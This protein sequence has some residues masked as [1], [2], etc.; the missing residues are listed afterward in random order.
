[1]KTRTK[2]PDR[3]LDVSRQLFNEKGFAATTTTE[4]AAAVG[5]A[6][7]NLTYHFSTKLDL[8]RALEEKAR[9]K[10]RSRRAALQSGPIADDYVEHLLFAM[11]LTWENR[12]MLRDGA[13]YSTGQSAEPRKTE[14]EAD[15]DEL[16]TLVQRIET[17]GMFRKDLGIVLEELTRS[18]WIVSRYWMDYLRETEG[19]QNI[20]WKDQ[21]RGI[22]QHYA[23]L[24][25]CLTATARKAFS[26]ALQHASSRQNE[27]IE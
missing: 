23:V 21:E 15:Y 24:L 14:F 12:F 26:A 22:R 2:T 18:L 20:H 7:G 25:P 16:L 4:I 19:L 27:V 6:Q 5:I 1:M 17:N 3:I 8:V 9:Q 11:E 13:Q 10:A